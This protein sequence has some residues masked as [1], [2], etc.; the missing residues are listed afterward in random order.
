ML[1]RRLQC[2]LRGYADEKVACRYW[3]LWG[4]VVAL[5][6]RE[7][8]LVGSLGGT[9][10]SLADR[11]CNTSNTRLSG[12]FRKTRVFADFLIDQTRFGDGAVTIDFRYTTSCSQSSSS[13]QIYT[14][15]RPLCNTEITTYARLRPQALASKAS[16]L[17]SPHHQ[18]AQT[19]PPA[20]PPPQAPCQPSPL[21][22]SHAHPP[23][24]RYSPTPSPCPCALTKC[25][26]RAE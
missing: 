6:S 12:I 20:T 22:H 11:R 9:V 23:H 25:R 5:G 2:S 26:R 21:H 17:T 15:K 10:D 16:K 14:P 18:P 3:R 24:P 19:P 7:V 13:V 4:V 8:I 1:M